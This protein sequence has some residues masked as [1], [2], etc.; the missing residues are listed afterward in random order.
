MKKGPPRCGSGSDYRQ[1]IA[2][3]NSLGRGHRHT[4]SAV[5]FGDDPR[6]NHHRERVRQYGL[7]QVLAICQRL[8]QPRSR[9]RERTGVEQAGNRW[10]ATIERVENAAVGKRAENRD[11]RSLPYTHR[12]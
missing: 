7:R 10:V 2:E 1:V 9:E 6:E 4:A 3:I 11:L 8:H 5:G 12:F